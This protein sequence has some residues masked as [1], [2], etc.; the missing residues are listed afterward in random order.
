MHAEAKGKLAEL[1]KAGDDAWED[2]KMG[3][4]SAKNSLGTALKSAFSRFK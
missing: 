3:I 4:E 2:L 1:R